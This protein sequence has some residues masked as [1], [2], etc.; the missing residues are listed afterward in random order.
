M[1]EWAKHRLS[2]G[3]LNK[4]TPAATQP[5]VRALSANQ[6]SLMHTY[7]YGVTVGVDVKDWVINMYGRLCKVQIWDTAGQERF[8]TLTPSFYRGAHAVIVAYE[9]TDTQV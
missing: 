8:R 5:L 7:R 4:N 6:V 9:I 1:L 2:D 3:S